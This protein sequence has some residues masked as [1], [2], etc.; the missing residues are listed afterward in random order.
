MSQG[1]QILALLVLSNGF[2]KRANCHPN[3]VK[4][5]VFSQKFT[6]LP[7]GFGALLQAPACGRKQKTSLT[8]QFLVAHLIVICV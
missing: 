2:I 3:G 6:N 1:L 7:K 5:A 4:M 8:K